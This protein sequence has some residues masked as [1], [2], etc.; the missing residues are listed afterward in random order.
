MMFKIVNLAGPFDY[1][2]R[3]QLHE[4]LQ[5]SAGAQAEKQPGPVC[6]VR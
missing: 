2:L 3:T 1:E 5:A 6:R 4:E